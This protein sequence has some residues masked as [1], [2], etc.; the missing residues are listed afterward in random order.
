MGTRKKRE[1][2]EDLWYGGELPTAPGHPFYKQAFS[3]LLGHRFVVCNF[4]DEIRDFSAKTFRQL[5]SGNTC[6]LDRVME[7]G[8]DYQVCVR[9]LQSNANQFGNLDQMI[10]VGFRCTAF[11]PL[12]RMSLDSEMD[13]RE[14]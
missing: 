6:V 9:F 12:I 14:E 2:Q 10:H 1:R 7:E 13:S 4:S 8:R 3:L 11:A 5:F